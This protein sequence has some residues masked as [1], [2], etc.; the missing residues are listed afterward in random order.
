M[1]SVPKLIRRFVGLLLLSFILLVI[2]NIL[3]FAVIVSRQ[4][5]NARPWKTAEEVAAA[6]TE[7]ENGVLLSDE[8]AE[9]L[10]LSGAWAILIDNDT[11]TVVWHSDNLPK[12]VPAGY[13]L[14]DIAGLTR[15][16][17]DGYPTFTSG[18][19]SGLVVLGFPKTSFWKHMWPSWDYQLI[20][21]APQ[22]AL[23]VVI[24]NV[25][26][27]L[28]IYM[29][30]STKLLR[31]VKP[32]ANAIRALP[33]GDPVYIRETGLLSEIAF[34]IN[35]TSEVLQTQKRQL[36][37]RETARASWIAGVSHDIRT[38]LS[39]VMGYADQLQAAPGL[40]EEERH[41]AEIILKQSERIGKLVSDL[42][43]ASRLEYNMQPV[44][45]REENAV[46]L[47]RQAA[48]DFANAD[49]DGKYPI[50]WETDEKLLVC[51]VNADGELL[52][53]AVANLLQNSAVHNED[54]CT[55]YVSVEKNGESCVIH[56]EDDGIGA[57]DEQIAK[58][59]SAPHSMARD[60]TAAE[61]R[62][63]LGLLIV[64]Q[65]ADSHHGTAVV[66]RSRYGGFAAAITLECS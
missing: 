44:R 45:L 15:G 40:T 51:R 18:T 66:G 62:H 61:P 57:S 31:S 29:A 65:I 36:Q 59:N 10:R 25:A 47:V 58:L 17:I 33:S 37:K 55:I 22:I 42:N 63:G 26:V 1:K 49:P 34:H 14:S 24:A 20:A 43:L 16:Y 5:A 12:S 9:T 8:G 30:A 56:V 32:I 3:I 27:I 48:A 38:P 39:T 64:R 60:E 21:H 11:K 2:V 35:S 23:V 52:R 46:A 6:L 54:G 4:M 28:L 7:T 41:K 50:R 19:E 13:T 53:R